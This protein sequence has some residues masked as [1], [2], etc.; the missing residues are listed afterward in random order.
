[1]DSLALRNR[2]HV[3]HSSGLLL[4]GWELLAESF[5]YR[6]NTFS[7]LRSIRRRA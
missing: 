4:R 1:M 5:G 6:F 3:L 2:H 7:T